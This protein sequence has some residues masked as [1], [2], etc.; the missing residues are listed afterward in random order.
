TAV[1]VERGLSA[2]ELGVTAFAGMPIEFLDRGLQRFGVDAALVTEF[3]QRR[4]LDEVPG[5]QERELRHRA[6]HGE[7]EGIAGH[8]T[9]VA[10]LPGFSD[11][12]FG[13]GGIETGDVVPIAVRFVDEA[14]PRTGDADRSWFGPVHD[15]GKDPGAAIAIGKQRHRTPG[16][17]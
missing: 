16:G 17:R 13:S 11:L 6:R 8:G 12:S 4:R 7:A 2:A 1:A 5:A 3:V 15:V 9:G 10:D 14:A